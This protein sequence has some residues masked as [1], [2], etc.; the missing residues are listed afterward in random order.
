MHYN[1]R[2]Y[3]KWFILLTIFY[4]GRKKKIVAVCDIGTKMADKDNQKKADRSDCR[5][6]TRS[7][8]RVKCAKPDTCDTADAYTP[9]FMPD[10]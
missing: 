4:D 9:T 5:S 3:R 2:L 10:K 6:Q 1:F 7:V 8:Q